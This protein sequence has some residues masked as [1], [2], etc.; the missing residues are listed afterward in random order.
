MTYRNP[1]MVE[2]MVPRDPDVARRIH[3]FFDAIGWRVRNHSRSEFDTYFAPEVG[4]FPAPTIAYWQTTNPDKIEQ[5]EHHTSDDPSQYA[6]GL[7]LPRLADL[8][9]LCLIVPSDDA[10]HSIFDRGGRLLEAHAHIRPREHAGRQEFRFS[11]PFNYALRVTADPG[12]EVNLSD[13][14]LVGRRIDHVGGTNY[15]VDEVV[16][17][18]EGYE[19][20]GRLTRDFLYTQDVAGGHPAGT[21]YTRS[22][23]E[24]LHGTTLVD[25]R[26]VP[27]FRIRE[28]E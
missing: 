21:R 1:L 6:R 28:P 2:L 14:P 20:T 10:V 27:I 7:R 25:G 9:E 17:R 23:E 26:E 11:D 22:E 18:A 4:A 5:F 3:G 19:T 16:W 8:V 15:T 24:L 12:Y 13:E